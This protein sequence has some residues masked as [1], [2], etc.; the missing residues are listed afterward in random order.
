MNINMTDFFLGFFQNFLSL[1]ACIHVFEIVMR[2]ILRKHK[3]NLLYL[4]AILTCIASGWLTILFGVELGS[5]VFDLRYVPLVFVAMYF[6]GSWLI[7][8]TAFSIGIFRFFYGINTASIFGFSSLVLIGFFYVF[9]SN[10]ISRLPLHR[11]FRASILI[12]L[13]ITLNSNLIIILKSIDLQEYLFEILPIQFPL[14]LGFGL[15][16]IFIVHETEITFGNVSSLMDAAYRDPLTGLY[17]RRHLEKHISKLQEKHIKDNNLISVAYIDIDHF[18]FIN[19]TYGHDVGDLTIKIVGKIISKTIREL[20]YVARVGGEEYF[21][22]LENCSANQAFEIMDR[23]RASVEA[24]AFP[25][26]SNRQPTISVGLATAQELT[27]SL[28]K[29]ADIAL[30]KAKSEG[31]NKVV[32]SSYKITM[33]KSILLENHIR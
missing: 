23:V 33:P 2:N 4:I 14:T 3:K 5:Q 19:D 17:N 8:I 30:Y 32:H 28:C 10:W 21:V 20:D 6:P 11:L 24:K 26:L 15:L 12:T 31:R 27:E 1:V 7:F 9:I 16:L 22:I 29:E 13:A 25:L 18:K